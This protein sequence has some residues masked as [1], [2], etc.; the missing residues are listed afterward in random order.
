MPNI[1][2]THAAALSPL[3]APLATAVHHPNYSADDE[4]FLAA[5]INQF[6]KAAI[7]R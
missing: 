7:L 6:L 4:N 5:S 3:T 2:R 1:I